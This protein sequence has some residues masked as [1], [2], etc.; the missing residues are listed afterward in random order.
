MNIQIGHLVVWR[1]ETLRK[2]NDQELIIYAVYAGVW[3]AADRDYTARMS[4]A[5]KPNVPTVRI[6]VE[7]VEPA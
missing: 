2:I 7:R 1:H 3:P 5:S 4:I 6:D